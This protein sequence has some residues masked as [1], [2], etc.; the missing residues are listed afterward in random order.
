MA[1]NDLELCFICKH[2][3]R[4]KNHGI[5]ASCKYPDYK[6]LKIKFRED[7]DFDDVAIVEDC[8]GFET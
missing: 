3:K 4:V 7:T 8:S 6:N 2:S 1:A 5:Y